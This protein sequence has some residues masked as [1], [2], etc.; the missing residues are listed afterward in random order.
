MP[1][2]PSPPGY[3]RHHLDPNLVRKIGPPPSA[4]QALF[5]HL[6]STVEARRQEDEA[7]A[8]ERIRRDKWR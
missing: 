5:G 7:E 4:A 8:N 3:E 2:K 6:R 1:R